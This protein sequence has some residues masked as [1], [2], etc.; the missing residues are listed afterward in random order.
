MA[1]HDTITSSATSLIYHL[2][3]NPEWQEK[4]RAEVMAVTGGPDGQGNPRPLN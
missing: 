3:V 4:L 1:A 2:A